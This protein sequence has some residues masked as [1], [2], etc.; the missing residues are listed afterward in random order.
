MFIHFHQNPELS[1]G[2][3][4]TTERIAQ[5]LK[6]LGFEVHACGH[7]V[8]ITGLVGTARYMQANLSTWLSTLMLIAPPAEERIMGHVK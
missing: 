4:K 1:M 2:E 6:A 3:V 7:D 8:H 5:E